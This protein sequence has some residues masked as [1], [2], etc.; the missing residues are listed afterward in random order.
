MSSAV[1]FVRA[2]FNTPG[3]RGAAFCV[4]PHAV[5]A[6]GDRVDLGEWTQ[7]RGWCGWRSL[8]QSDSLWKLYG[9]QLRDMR[10]ILTLPTRICETPSQRAK[11]LDALIA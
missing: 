1:Q 6:Y 10:L 8:L 9:E 7:S 5:L 4:C 2:T 3:H 11:P